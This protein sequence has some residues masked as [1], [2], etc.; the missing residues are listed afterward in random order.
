VLELTLRIE[1]SEDLLSRIAAKT[2]SRVE[3]AGLGTHSGDETLLFFETSGVSPTT[4]ARSSTISS[5]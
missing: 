3:Y 2:G 4:F 5:R 1:G